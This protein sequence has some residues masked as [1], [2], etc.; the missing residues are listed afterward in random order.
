MERSELNNKLKSFPVLKFGAFLGMFVFV[1]RGSCIRVSEKECVVFVKECNLILQ[2]CYFFSE[3]VKSNYEFLIWLT[4]AA[5]KKRAK[6]WKI[7]EWEERDFFLKKNYISV[8][9]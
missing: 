5:F 4:D 3:D 2:K 6:R 9:K 1:L 8:N 7:G